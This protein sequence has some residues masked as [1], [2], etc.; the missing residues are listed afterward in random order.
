[1]IIWWWNFREI[2]LETT[3]NKSSFCYEGVNVLGAPTKT[4]C[5]CRAK[6][7]MKLTTANTT[8]PAHQLPCQSTCQEPFCFS[9]QRP[10]LVSVHGRDSGSPD[11]NFKRCSEIAPALGRL[12]CLDCLTGFFWIYLENHIQ[13]CGAKS[14][15]CF[16]GL[17]FGCL[18]AAPGF[19]ETLKHFLACP[20]TGGHRRGKQY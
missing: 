14:W 1:M 2:P 8:Q 11:C 12:D 18:G 5:I 7:L 20:G 4:K 6:E 15:F 3:R 10:D 9:S 13:K 19:L 16:S 17:G